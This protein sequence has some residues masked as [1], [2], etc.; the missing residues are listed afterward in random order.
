VSLVISVK[1]V[2]LVTPSKFMSSGKLMGSMITAQ[3]LAMQL[4]VRQ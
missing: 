2:I 3:E 4:V 1:Y